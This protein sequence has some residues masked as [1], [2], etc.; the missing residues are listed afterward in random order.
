MDIVLILGLII[1]SM[2]AGLIGSL[3]GLGGGIIVVPVLTILYGMPAAE[4]AAVSLVAIVAISSTSASSLIKNRISNVRIGLRLEVAAVAGAVVGAVIALYVQSWV[5]AL[6]FAMVLIYSAVYMFVRPE[7]LIP[8]DPSPSAE[9]FVYHDMKTG[10]DIRYDVQNVGTGMIGFALAGITSAL[11]GVGGGTIKIPVMNVHM[12]MPMK[13]ATATSS[14]VIGITAF[15]GAAVYL[16]CGVLDIEV[17]AFV[18][19]GAFVGSLIGLKLLPKINAGALRRYF[20]VL[21]IFLAS[22]MLLRIG[23]VI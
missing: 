17:A 13:A 11:S 20:S 19:M 3:F 1:L 5:L 14:Y 18:T 12:R 22:V 6:C 10:E 9:D 23:G 7:R 4:A 16:L 2:I 15:G 21:L 8:H